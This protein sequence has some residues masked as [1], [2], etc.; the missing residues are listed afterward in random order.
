MGNK[1]NNCSPIYE[2][3][4]EG[5][6]GL[7]IDVIES[8]HWCQKRPKMGSP[9]QIIGG[10]G[11][12]IMTS[13]N[14]IVGGPGPHIVI[15]ANQVREAPR[16]NSDEKISHLVPLLSNNHLMLLLASSVPRGGPRVD[17]K[18]SDDSPVKKS[19]LM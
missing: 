8:S 7:L 1:Y 4:R 11:P 3:E 15:S 2:L 18:T 19:D 17:L 5:Y 14:Q 16:S 13:A 10:P 6:G 12:H 9:N